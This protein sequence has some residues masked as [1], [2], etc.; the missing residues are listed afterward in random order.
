VIFNSDQGINT[1]PS[2][3]LAHP[4]LAIKEIDPDDEEMQALAT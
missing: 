2:V 1:F 4:K 3:I